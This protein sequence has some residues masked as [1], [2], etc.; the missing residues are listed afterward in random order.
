MPLHRVNV[1]VLCACSLALLSAAECNLGTGVVNTDPPTKC[2]TV[3]TNSTW[4]SSAQGIVVDITDPRWCPIIIYGA[5]GTTFLQSYAANVQMVASQLSPANPRMDYTFANANNTTLSTASYFFTI[6]GSTAYTTT[7]GSYNVGT[8]GNVANKQD[9][10]HNK[11][12]SV[13]GPATGDALLG[14]DY[15]VNPSISGLSSQTG[16]S[17]RITANTPK[18][19][20]PVTYQWWVDGISQGGATGSTNY[21]QTYTKTITTVGYHTFK[22]VV[23]DKRGNSYTLNKT[24]QITATCGGKI[25]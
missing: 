21:Y 24:V 4:S 23:V 19:Q 7:L 2:K 17:V 15:K 6:S 12:Y 13:N 18:V 16:G 14:Y 20:Q 10:V 22:S 3:A 9:F 1:V 8:A 5:V 11:I 25:C